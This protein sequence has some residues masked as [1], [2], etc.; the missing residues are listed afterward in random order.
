[1][2]LVVRQEW[3]LDHVLSIAS[4]LYPTMVIRCTGSATIR[5]LCFDA[6]NHIFTF[7]DYAQDN[8]MA[9]QPLGFDGRNEELTGVGIPIPTIGTGQ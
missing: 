1:M 9:I 7:E 2:V 5:P 6:P 3:V 8:M 4:F